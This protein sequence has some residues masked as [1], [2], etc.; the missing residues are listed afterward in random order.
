MKI[1]RSRKLILLLAALLL[2]VGGLYLG[3]VFDSA[4]KKSQQSIEAVKKGASKADSQ[5]ELSVTVLPIAEELTS[6][7]HAKSGDGRE[8]LEILQH[9]LDSYRQTI[10]KNPEGGENMLIVESLQ[11]GNS[12]RI[13]FLPVQSPFLNSKGEMIDRWGTPYFFHPISGEKMEIKSAG[14]DRELW[15]D[16]DLNL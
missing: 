16:D 1:D 14:P 6:E 10:G 13:S 5:P 11:G 2:I 15:T 12:R 8:D 3:G 4:T 7:L 9:L